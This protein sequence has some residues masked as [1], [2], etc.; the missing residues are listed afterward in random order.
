M[1]LRGKQLLLIIWPFLSLGNNY[2]LA[3]TMQFEHIITYH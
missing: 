2:S 3:N 1:L